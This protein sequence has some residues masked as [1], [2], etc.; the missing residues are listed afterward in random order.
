MPYI[1]RN[2]S[3][4]GAIEYETRSPEEIF[5]HH[6]EALRAEDLEGILLD[7]DDDACIVV[8]SSILRGKEAIARFFTR[9]LHLLPNAEWEVRPTFVDDVA[10][11]EWT[12]EST[13]SSVA[14]GVD[15]F[16]FADGLIRIQ[17]VHCTIDPK[18]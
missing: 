15:T 11:V 14:D 2:A 7:Y 3:R 16:V 17:T 9:A 18:E 5:A 13:K 8:G 12:A 1:V 10:L 4:W 6:V